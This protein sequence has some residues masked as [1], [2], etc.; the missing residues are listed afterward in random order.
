MS[1][2]IL[3]IIQALGWRVARRKELRG[4][5]QITQDNKFQKIF[6]TVMNMLLIYFFASIKLEKG[7][8]KFTWL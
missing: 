7:H 2:P 4:A 3:N 1:T 8:K 6:C 5:K